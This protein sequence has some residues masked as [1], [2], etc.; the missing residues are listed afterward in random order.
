MFAFGG[1][2]LSISGVESAVFTNSHSCF[3]NYA[4]TKQK[5]E[6]LRNDRVEAIGRTNLEAEAAGTDSL[7]EEADRL[8]AEHRNRM[9][10]LQEAMKV[11]QYTATVAQS[12]PGRARL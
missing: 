8:L 1:L 10:Q 7:R 4:P 9:A 6:D 3:L 5:M 11:P 2:I 12:R